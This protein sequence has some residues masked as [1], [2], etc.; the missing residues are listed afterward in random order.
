MLWASLGAIAP[1]QPIAANALHARCRAGSRMIHAAVSLATG[2]GLVAE[3]S[4]SALQRRERRFD[5]GRGLQF[6]RDF[7]LRLCRSARPN[8]VVLG[9]KKWAGALARVAPIAKEAP[10]APPSEAIPR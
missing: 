5:S 3:W 4:C 10:R 8:G 6:Q 9:V 1:L 2:Y 7:T